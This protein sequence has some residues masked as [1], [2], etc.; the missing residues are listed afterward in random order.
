MTHLG[1]G[2]ISPCA[3][4]R[5][6]CPPPLPRCRA[7]LRHGEGVSHKANHSNF[8]LSRGLD[9]GCLQVIQIWISSSSAGL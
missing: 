8:S 3:A 7:Q 2:S 4:R 5:K 6:L 9:F 1:K